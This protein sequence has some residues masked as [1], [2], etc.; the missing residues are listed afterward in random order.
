MP[1]CAAI[2]CSNSAKKGF[3]MKRFPRVPSI[4]KEWLIKTRRNHWTPTDYSCL[5]EVGRSLCFSTYNCYI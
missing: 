2:N 4:R 3:L 1:G 5:C